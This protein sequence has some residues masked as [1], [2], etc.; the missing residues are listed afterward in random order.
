[1]GK[2]LEEGS[3]IVLTTSSE[4]VSTVAKDEKI[5]QMKNVGS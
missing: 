5:Y 4:I 2:F 1:M 3:K